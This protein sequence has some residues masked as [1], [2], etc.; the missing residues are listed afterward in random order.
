M[1]EEKQ[2]N[3]IQKVKINN[4]PE[5]INVKIDNEIKVKDSKWWKDARF[6]LSGLFSI[7]AVA[8]S[9]IALLNSFGIFSKFDLQ[10]DVA[11]IW[12]SPLS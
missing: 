9:V 7:A 2:K 3:E 6:V 11:G 5:N 1:E 8:V 12:L 10:I 4:F